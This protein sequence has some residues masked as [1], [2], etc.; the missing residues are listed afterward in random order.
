MT[1][2]L[3]ESVND[4]VSAFN[5][6]GDHDLVIAPGTYDFSGAAIDQNHRTGNYIIR[7]MYPGSV[8]MLG[9]GTSGIHA[10]PIAA[11]SLRL[12]PG[13]TWENWN[14]VLTS[15]GTRADRF[16][17]LDIKGQVF[18]NVRY[19]VFVVDATGAGLGPTLGRASISDCIVETT[20]GWAFF[21]FAHCSSFRFNRNRGNDITQRFLSLGVAQEHDRNRQFIRDV[22]VSRNV[23]SNVHSDG[24][25]DAIGSHALMVFGDRVQFDYNHIRDVESD[26]QPS[27]FELSGGIYTK[28][29]NVKIFG[30]TLHN[31]GN[32]DPDV[33]AALGAITCKGW[34][35]EVVAEIPEIGMGGF[36]AEIYKNEISFNAGSHADAVGILNSAH[37][38]EIYENV[39]HRCKIQSVGS[40]VPEFHYLPI[41]YQRYYRNEI[42]DAPRQGLLLSAFEDS[43]IAHDNH[44][45]RFGAQFESVERAS[46][47]HVICVDSP[48]DP[49]RLC[50]NVR[51]RGND[52]SDCQAGTVFSKSGVFIQ[53]SDLLDDEDGNETYE[54]SNNVE[55]ITDTILD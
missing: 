17:V 37:D 24:P 50:K 10:L 34:P 9:G 33:L 29:S 30:N 1:Y 5:T 45:E 15:V 38:T 52:I 26:F 28:A 21:V 6:P 13:I 25:S 53:D 8:T 3:I 49:G 23:V 41:N 43:V 40:S 44:I 32:S 36:H 7:P 55:G 46:A 42:Y 16:E 20:A 48:V 19:A 39:L 11:G 4:F 47:I 51:L 12:R 54:N 31:T 2:H 14:R 22:V 18:R 27:G 35:P